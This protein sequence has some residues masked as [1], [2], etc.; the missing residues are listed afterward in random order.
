MNPAFLNIILSSH[1]S[2]QVSNQVCDPYEENDEN[3]LPDPNQIDIVDSIYDD[4]VEP[5]QQVEQLK[6]Q[7]QDYKN[8]VDV[9]DNILEQIKL[10][11]RDT[12]TIN[13]I[14]SNSSVNI[15]ELKECQDK[16]LDYI[17][18]IAEMLKK[19]SIKN[20]RYCSIM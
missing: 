13:Q 1:I 7:V 6:N 20:N 15:A 12:A 3:P 10:T 11:Q 17:V 19:E 5:V 2:N 18:A 8:S 4:I 9:L 16:I 14:V